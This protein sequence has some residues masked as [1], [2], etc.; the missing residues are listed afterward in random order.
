MATQRIVVSALSDA[1][2]EAPIS[3]HFGRCP[4]FVVVDVEDGEVATVENV[5]NPYYG[6]HQPGEVPG[7]VKSL[8][9]DVMVSG[10]MG[11]R[12]VAFFNQFGIDVA[13]GASGTVG[14]TL[15]CFLAGDLQG[16]APCSESVAHG[17]AH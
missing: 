1:G 12:A 5:A 6:N 7:F 3:P 2:L 8:G 4:Y 15:D 14:E 9:A 11:G 17:H 10:G 16:A 13:T